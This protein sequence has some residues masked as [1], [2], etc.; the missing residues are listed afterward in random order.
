MPAGA[1]PADLLAVHPTQ[2]YEVAIMT[3]V[4]MLLWHWRRK[5][6]WGTGALFGLYLVFA[7]LERFAVE[8]LRAKDDR[9]F[10][11]L[12]LAQVTSLA[13]VAIGVFWFIRMQNLGSVDARRIPRNRV[14]EW[15]EVKRVKSGRPA[16]RAHPA[17]PLTAHSLRLSLDLDCEHRE[18]IAHPVQLRARLRQVRVDPLQ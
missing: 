14:S 15:K 11:G 18:P 16:C 7:G 17:S 8:F 12:T 13:I 4:F 1:N 9:F 10:G 3:A 5:A 2:L 6:G